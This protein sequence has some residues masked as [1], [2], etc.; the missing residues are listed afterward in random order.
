M[1]DDVLLNL[2]TDDKTILQ[3]I[4][5]FIPFI[6][7]HIPQISLPCPNIHNGLVPRSYIQRR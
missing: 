4:K 7:F 6:A 3:E 1:S 2:D 5:R